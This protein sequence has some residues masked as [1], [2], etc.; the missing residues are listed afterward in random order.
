MG[1]LTSVL[2]FIDREAGLTALFATSFLP[3]GDA[4]VK[5]LMKAYELGLYE[6]LE[7]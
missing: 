5:E 6:Q 1:E 2:Q 4:Q 7:S 3:S